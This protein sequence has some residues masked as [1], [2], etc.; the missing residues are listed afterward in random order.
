M[1]YVDLGRLSNQ[2]NKK[3]SKKKFLRFGILT[4]LLGFVIYA[5][6]ILYWPIAILTEQILKQ[7]ASVFSLIS[8]P[9]GELK[10]VDGRTNFLLVGIDKRANIPYT[11]TVDNNVVKKNGFNT[12]TILVVSIDNSTKKVSMI[13]IPRDTWVTTKANGN[14]QTYSGKINSLYAIGDMQDYPDGG[15]MGLLKSKVQ[16][17]L[18]IPIQYTAR[19]D[20][21]GFRK[22]IDLLGGIDVVV[23]NTFDDYTYPRTGY[24]DSICSDGTYNCQVM[25]IHFDKGVAH[26]DGT[27]A[28][29]FARSRHALGP[30]G[31][32]FAR[33]KRQQKVL[34]AAKDK[35]LQIQNLFDP[36]KLN[37]LFKEF[38]QSVDTD[39]DISAMTALYNMS[40]DLKT[41]AINSLVLSDANYLYVSP[42]D[43]YG[44]AYTLVPNGNN[45]NEVRQAVS[46]LLNNKTS[47]GVNPASGNSN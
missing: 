29:E 12:D 19:I 43:Q 6:Y 14:F 25:H 39:I 27:T 30:E 4:L 33:A 28:L 9:K 2:N 15:G 47:N 42:V 34:V 1:Q 3:K 10:V 37:S 13:S 22:G 16:D 26:M 44:G 7:P 5:G 31:S 35:A 17:I 18:G 20:F 38:G 21:E 45:W 41:D 23:D 46:D 32:D 8:N 24:E 36:L 40:K 11:Y